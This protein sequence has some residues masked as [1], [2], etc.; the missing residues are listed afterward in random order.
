MSDVGLGWSRNDT[1]ALGEGDGPVVRILGRV[2]GLEGSGNVSVFR[3]PENAW[4]IYA[5]KCCRISRSKRFRK[6]KIKPFLYDGLFFH[7]LRF[8]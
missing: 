1:Y 5:E 4:F 7:S 3:G 8:L 2:Q 6:Q